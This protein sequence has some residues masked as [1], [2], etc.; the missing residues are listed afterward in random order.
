MRLI[1]A[2]F[3]LLRYLLTKAQTANDRLLIG[4]PTS[5]TLRTD[6]E[7]VRATFELI[8]QIERDDYMCIPQDQEELQSWMHN[9]LSLYAGGSETEERIARVIAIEKSMGLGDA[10]DEIWGA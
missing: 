1:K 9:L 10:G 2:Q 4:H 7:K 6:A 5:E 8:A 3:D